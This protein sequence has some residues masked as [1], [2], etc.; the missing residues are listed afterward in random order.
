MIRV[1]NNK[2][3]R[4]RIYFLF[5][6][7]VMAF[8][9]LIYKL[10]SIQYIYASKYQSYA[11]YQHMDQFTVNAKRG[12]IL[13][14]NEIELA[15]SLIEKTVYAN[16]KIVISA[17]QEAEA[18]SKIL[19]MDAGS[20]E[21]KLDS[22]ELGFVYI[23][24]QIS[25]E[26]AEL[27]NQL[28]LPG[29]YTQN[30]TKRYYPQNDLAAAIVGFTGLD[31]N[32]LNGVELEYEKLLRGIDGKYIIEKD[33]YGKI[34]PGSKNNYIS[35]MD[36]G[37]VVL[38][39]DSQIQYIAQKKLEE[40]TTDYKAL[41]SIVVVMN[42]QTGEIY[43]MAGYPGFELNN[44][45]QYDESLYKNLGISFT[46]EPGSTFKIVN[47]SSAIDNNCIKYDQ[48]FNLPPSIKVGDK[49]IKEA[50]RTYNIKY[51]TGEIIKY[52]SNIGA[53]TSALSMGKKLFYESIRKYGFGEPTGIDLPGEEGGILYNY[54]DWSAS[55]IGALAIGQSISITPLQLV[56]AAC[57]IANG[58]YLVTPNIVKEVRLQNEK[59]EYFEEKE[60][61]RIISETTAQ[62]VKDMM[63]ACV[64]DGSG[65]R[66]QIENV[67][68]CG[69]TGTGQKVNQAGIGYSEGRVITS[70]VGFAPYDNP[71]VAIVVV[72]DEPH[73]PDNEIFGGTVA[74]PIFKEIMNFS[75]KRLRVGQYEA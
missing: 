29:I 70:F 61:V 59:V 21:Q 14:R 6:L 42:P 38:T 32:G 23:K 24:R 20:I 67:K 56:R 3:N 16:P 19:D 43:A 5:I 48:T 33:V 58:G 17:E 28:N 60:K 39:I 15:T 26:V 41:R 18:L 11:E 10:V 74:A 27:I 46:Y 72:I 1:T 34:I 49:V 31:N 53:V 45:Q 40:V 63:L 64:D 69:K 37:D 4:K 22:K 66:A 2:I 44:Y 73:G 71:Q 75:L 62:E 25:S 9:L 55:T 12:K 57:V 65:T 50:F 7:F 54:K 52:S 47:I 13:D 68:V 36:G 51:T 35:P 8:A 30:E